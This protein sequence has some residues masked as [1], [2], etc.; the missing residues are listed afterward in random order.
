VVFVTE[1]STGEGVFIWRHG[2][3]SSI[4][5][6]GEHAPGGGTFSSTVGFGAIGRSA[7]NDAG[8]V[9]IIFALEPFTFPVGVNA[10]VYRYSHGKGTLRAVVVP[11]VTLVPG[12]GDPFA[13][14]FVDASL[15]N[16]GDIAFAALIP[17]ADL[18]PG[19]PGVDGL[20]LGI[21]IFRADKHDHITRLVVP[22]DLAPKGGIFD[23]VWHP[24]INDE[25]DV[26]FGGHVQGE[27]CIPTTNKQADII[28]CDESVYLMDHK[29]GEIISIAHQGDRAPGGGTF[30]I[31]FGPHLNNAGALV[32][33]GDLTS[34]PGV[35]DSS[36][37]YLYSNGRTRP[38]A[39]PGDR[40]PGGGDLVKAGI[41]AVSYN[42]N[43]HGEVSFS[44]MVT[45]GPGFATG[46]Y[47]FAHGKLHLVARKGT[48]IPGLGTIDSLPEQTGSHINDD[49]QILF[50]ATL[51][52]GQKTVLLVANPKE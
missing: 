8:D 12:S 31:A 15:N 51:D 37:V 9:A 44:A 35:G 17:G 42:L 21:G 23:N 6:G 20:G 3:L 26:A 30:R 5:R 19:P 39:R 4:M 2:R 38:V 34:P 32:F 28:Q 45:D 14:T 25:R 33:I 22:G 48:V 29:T 10:G 7:L 47:V 36:G 27:E 11:G 50:Q 46:L 52:N 1:T 40:M 16:R 49:G 43:N 24:W 41:N 18:E 13:G